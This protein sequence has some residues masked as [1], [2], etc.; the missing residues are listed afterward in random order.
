MRLQYKPTSNNYAELTMVNVAD[1]WRERNVWYQ[2][3]PA[4]RRDYINKMYM[5]WNP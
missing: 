4:S 5:K 2:V 1:I 3:G